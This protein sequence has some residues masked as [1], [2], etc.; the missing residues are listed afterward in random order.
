MLKQVAKTLE[1]QLQRSTDFFARYGGEEFILLFPRV[2]HEEALKLGETLCK[3]VRDLSIPHGYSRAAKVVTASVG[4]ATCTPSP[5]MA[6]RELISLADKCLYK[7]KDAGRDKCVAE[8][9]AA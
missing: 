1:R 2:S 5:H 9:K 4:I 6:P 8:D 7:A 3:A